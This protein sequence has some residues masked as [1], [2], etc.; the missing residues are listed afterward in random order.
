MVLII[1]VIIEFVAHAMCMN[2]KGVH[3]TVINNKRVNS[4][5]LSTIYANSIIECA[6]QC[7]MAQ[8]C[9]QANF[10]RNEQCELLSERQETEVMDDRQSKLLRKFLFGFWY[11]N[12]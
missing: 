10:K 12:D 6:V 9:S 5:I 2:I 4:E 11:L 7:S 1:I 8:G 3:F